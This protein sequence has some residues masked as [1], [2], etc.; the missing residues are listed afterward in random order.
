MIGQYDLPVTILDYLGINDVEFANSPGRSFRTAL[1]G[2]NGE[3]VNEVYYEMEET[4]GVRT[5]E[6]A[7]W[8][9][10]AGVGEPELYDMKADPGQHHDL[11]SDPAY[12]DVVRKLSE[13][14]SSFFEK[15]ASSQYDLWKGGVA[16]GSVIRPD[17]FRALYGDDWA[18]TSEV[19]PPFQE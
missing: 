4:R 3:W 1:V 15:Y 17:M 11:A 10:L 8:Q 5:P 19:L 14:L 16:K 6:Y 9:R 13:K 18:P 7:Y 2:E 12:A